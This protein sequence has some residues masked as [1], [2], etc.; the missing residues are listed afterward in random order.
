MF[1]KRLRIGTEWGGKRDALWFKNTEFGA[2]AGEVVPPFKPQLW[3]CE[4]PGDNVTDGTGL[5]WM[6]NELL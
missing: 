3:S 1:M 2:R 5:L 4:K 6:E